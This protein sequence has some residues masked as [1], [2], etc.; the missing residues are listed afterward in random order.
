[1]PELPEVE[2]VRVGAQGWFAG[3]TIEKVQVFNPRAVR[4]HE[5]GIADFESRLAGAELGDFFRRGKFMWAPLTSGDVLTFHLGMSGQVLA[6]ELAPGSSAVAPEAASRSHLRA[7]IEFQDQRE[8]LH[9]VDQRTFGYLR[10]DE[11]LT[12]WGAG[13]LAVPASLAHIAPDPFDPDFDLTQAAALTKRK[14][15]PI[16]SVL[17]DQSVVSGIG[18]IYAD[19]ALWRA[20]LRWS[21]KASQLSLARIEAL[22]VAATEVMAEATKAGG[23]SFD[24]LY[25]NVDGA[26]GYFER[27]LAAYGREGEPCPRCGTAI[28]R[29]QFANRSSFRCPNCQ[30]R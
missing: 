11:T 20:K 7:A 6:S 21:T 3:R 14:H 18:N 25:V 17:L 29:E 26:S 9:F 5:S 8:S 12:T 27:S 16:K 13:D 4:H 28:I 24:A 22:Y 10:I 2:S 1:M 15:R 19:E 30:R 23:T